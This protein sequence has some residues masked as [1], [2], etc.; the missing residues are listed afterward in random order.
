MFRDDSFSRFRMTTYN[1]EDD[2]E[3]QREDQ[4]KKGLELEIKIIDSKIKDLE[5]KKKR[6]GTA[7]EVYTERNK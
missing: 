6:L 2:K 4:F 5:E 1:Y 3:K 7:L